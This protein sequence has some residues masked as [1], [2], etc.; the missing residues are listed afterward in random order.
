MKRTAL[1]P[2]RDEKLLKNKFFS[3][4]YYFQKQKEGSLQKQY[5]GRATKFLP[6]V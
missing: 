5:R 2:V 1:K 6:D 4:F 3:I